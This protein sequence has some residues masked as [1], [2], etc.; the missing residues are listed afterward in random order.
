MKSRSPAVLAT[1]QRFVPTYRF[2]QADE[3]LIE[4]NLCPLAA[5]DRG[6]TLLN[7]NVAKNNHTDAWAR[8][9][10]TILATYQP[11]LIFLQEACLCPTK[12]HAVGLAEMAWAF[13]PNLLD[14][15]R[16]TYSGVLVAAKTAH[17]TGQAILTQHY[18]PLTQ[19]PKISLVVE[20]PLQNSSQTLLVINIHGIN[21]V[22]LAKFQAQLHQLEQAIARHSG[23]VIFAGDFNTWNR[24]R[25]EQLQ[26][27]VN[28]LNLIQA[29]F[30]LNHQQNI[31]RFLLSPPLDHVFYRGLSEI[32]QNAKVLEQ[33]TSSDHK[34][35]IVELML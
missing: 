35:M 30:N 19:T 8:E 16:N 7:W 28:R 22:R 27:I 25:A 31:K 23:P 13:A 11:D 6:L 33:M 15:H 5:F 20:Y 34:P 18:E 17:L 21:F 32:K 29:S 12:R 9:F 14:A 10:L 24:A 4:R 26:G 1:F 2:L 3:R